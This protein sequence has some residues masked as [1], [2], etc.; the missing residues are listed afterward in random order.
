MTF[1]VK[2]KV[3]GILNLGELTASA[4]IDHAHFWGIGLPDHIAILEN[5]VNQ[6]P[7]LKR[8]TKLAE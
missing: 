8:I 6:E 2:V 1:R 3:D 4:L 7:C 5:V